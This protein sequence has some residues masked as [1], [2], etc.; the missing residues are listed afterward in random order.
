MTK[1]RAYVI[2]AFMIVMVFWG[3]ELIYD[4][5]FTP[6]S[7]DRF[8]RTVLPG[9]WVGQLS[10]DS[11]RLH[12]V[13]LELRRHRSEQIGDCVRCQNLEGTARFCDARGDVRRYEIDGRVEDRDG[14]KISI[15]IKPTVAPAAGE[16]ETGFLR[17]G[18]DGADSLSLEAELHWQPGAS[19]AIRVDRSVHLPL[20]RG[21]TSDFEAACR[22]LTTS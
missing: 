1:R 6:W 22:R 20:R 16:V 18:W 21:S 17:G 9:T 4:V 13:L 2:V 8:G 5:V 14:R 12:G 10:T 11:G 19:G 3:S 7:N 15:G